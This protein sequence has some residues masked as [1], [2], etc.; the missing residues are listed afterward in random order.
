M[1]RKF[2]KM[3]WAAFV[4]TCCF[5]VVFGAAYAQEMVNSSY[6]PVVI[7]E[8]FSKTMTRMANAKPEIMKRQMDLLEERYDMSNRPAD[9][10]MMS[11]GDQGGSRRCPCESAR[12]DDLGKAGA[13]DATSR[14]GKRGFG[15][16]AS[17]RCLTRTTRKAVW[18]FPSFISTRS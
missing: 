3:K 4:L 16:K 9:G 15:P 14:S 2:L 12:R 6:S 17:C 13:N 11:G 5:I 10:V 7:K 8:P 18:S 1:G